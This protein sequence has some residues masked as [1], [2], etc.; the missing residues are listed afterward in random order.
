MECIIY[1]YHSIYE[2]FVIETFIKFGIHVIEIE[3]SGSDNSSFDKIS[4]VLVDKI[5]SGSPVSFV[6]SINFFPNISELCEVLNTLYLCWS[7]DSPVTELFSKSICNSH[8]RLFLFDKDQFNRFSKYN[9]NNIFHLP[10]ATDPIYWGNVL[11]SINDEDR[12]RFSCDISFVGSLYTEKNPVNDLIFDEYTQ[13]FV[14]G[15]I[16]SQLLIF[17]KYF[18]EDA[19][20]DK[21]TKNIAPSLKINPNDVVE[22]FEKYYVANSLLGYHITEKE[23]I[24]TL[25]ALSNHFNVSLFTESPSTSL[26]KVKNCGRAS[27][28]TEMPKIFNLSKI[29]L[30]ITMRS[31]SSGIPLRV[32]DILGCHGFL[33]SNYQE[34][35]LDYFEPGKDLEIYSSTEELLDKCEYYLSNESARNSIASSGYEKITKYHTMETRMSQMISMIVN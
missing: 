33:I 12:R 31:I 4:N 35:L 32:F 34:E 11:N 2:P 8:N 17:G 22:S 7:V 3:L 16:D 25:S 14:N 21:I 24:Q 23:R 30:N 26:P 5:D 27:T 15:L 28:L 9:P 29:N 6:F 1:R 20:T 13:G 18:L 19:L 10:L